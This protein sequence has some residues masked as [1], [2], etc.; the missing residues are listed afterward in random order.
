MAS[1]YFRTAFKE[2]TTTILYVYLIIIIIIILAFQFETAT[3]NC[4]KIKTQK[5]YEKRFIFNYKRLIKVKIAN[6][7]L[8]QLLGALVVARHYIYLPRGAINYKA[9][10]LYLCYLLF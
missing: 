5:F 6:D 3:F 8:V 9:R 10:A 7:E 4:W 1:I 2:C